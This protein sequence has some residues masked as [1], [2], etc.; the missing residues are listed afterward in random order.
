VR[1][2]Y[3]FVGGG[4]LSFLLVEVDQFTEIVQEI[5]G[6]ILLAESHLGIV[7]HL[8]AVFAFEEEDEKHLL[9]CLLEVV[10]NRFVDQH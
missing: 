6:K 5:D 1:F 4:G 8:S 10:N 2:L 7:H 9:L 3:G